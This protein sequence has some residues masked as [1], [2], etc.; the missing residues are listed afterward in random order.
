MSIEGNKTFFVVVFCGPS[1][2]RGVNVMLLT[3]LL[4]ELGFFVS[5]KA[6]G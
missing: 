6:E 5:K 2:V 4:R 3:L 1:Q